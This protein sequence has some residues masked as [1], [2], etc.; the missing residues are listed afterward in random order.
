[1]NKTNL[2]YLLLKIE[3]V[4]GKI[5]SMERVNSVTNDVYILSGISKKYVLKLI[6]KDKRIGEDIDAVLLKKSK[7]TYFRKLL[8]SFQAKDGKQVL[9]LEYLKGQILANIY[10]DKSSLPSNLFFQFKDFL[11]KPH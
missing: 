3:R 1:M 7:N 10:E 6:N 11:I 8:M 9:L 5:S 2:S 4:V